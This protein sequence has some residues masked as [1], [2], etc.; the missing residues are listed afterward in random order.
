MD[1]H[2]LAESLNPQERILLPLL[3]FSQLL[4]EIKTSLSKDEILRTLQL[5]ENKKLIT[6]QT[7]VD[8]TIINNYDNEFLPEIRLLKAIENKPLTISEVKER[9]DLDENEFSVAMRLKSDHCIQILNGKIEIT[10]SGKEYLKNSLTLKKIDRTVN[11]NNYQVMLRL[12]PKKDSTLTKEEKEVI[13]KMK[14]RGVL[15]KVK[16]EKNITIKLTELGKQLQKVKLENNLIESVTPFI[17]KN[18][19]NQK[20]RRYDIQAPVPRIYAGRRHFVNEA[21]EYIKRIWLDLGFKEMQGNYIQPSLWNFDALFQPQDH[22]AREMHDTFFMKENAKKLPKEIVAR[23]KRAH[24]EGVAES[25]GWQ[26]SWQESEAKKNVLRTHTTCLSAITLANLKDNE[27][28]AKFFSVGKV[29]RNETLDWKHLFEFDQSEGIVVDPNA[30]FRHLQS[31]LKEFFNKMGFT[32]VRFRPG[33]FPYVEPGLECEVY[34]P[35]KKQ[36]VEIGGAGIFRPEVTIP[37]LKKDIPVLA[38]GIGLGRLIMEYYEIHDLREFNKNDL[39]QLKEIKL[40]LK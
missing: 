16:V 38:W 9:R 31:Y 40:W 37:L 39:K 4:E 11:V 26:Y 32:K 3:K 19:Q 2:S 1:V 29:F 5:L 34:N 7:M 14:Q 15:I 35:I 8:E 6:T 10:P 24:E 22:P 13:D 21:T 12:L 30:N 33:Y 20:F 28:P 18:Y 36:W 25:K 23:I 17:I 27:I